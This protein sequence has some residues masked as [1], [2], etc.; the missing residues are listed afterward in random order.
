M[1]LD[2]K[3]TENNYSSCTNVYHIQTSIVMEMCS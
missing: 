3:V 2:Y 1:I